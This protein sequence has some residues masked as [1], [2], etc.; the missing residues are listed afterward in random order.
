MCALCSQ[1]WLLCDPCACADECVLIRLVCLVTEYAR[2]IVIHFCIYSMDLIVA[3]RTPLPYATKAAFKTDDDNSECSRDSSASILLGL[4]HVPSNCPAP[5]LR[6]FYLRIV[7]TIAGTTKFRDL[8]V[9]LVSDNRLFRLRTV[10][11]ERILKHSDVTHIVSVIGSENWKIPQHSTGIPGDHHTWVSP[12][13]HH[14][15]IKNRWVMLA[16]SMR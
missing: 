9:Q 1:I 7:A 13:A 4:P 12:I 3:N 16:H 5:E 8:T 14:H 10:Y 6:R 2:P 15:I 11:K